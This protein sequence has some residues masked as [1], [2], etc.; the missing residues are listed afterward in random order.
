[1]NAQRILTSKN[2][3]RTVLFTPVDGPTETVTVPI[4]THIYHQVNW[5]GVMVTKDGVYSR[6]PDK[7]TNAHNV[8]RFRGHELT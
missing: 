1:M 5:F 3:N 7:W 4:N 6:H 8:Q 2:G